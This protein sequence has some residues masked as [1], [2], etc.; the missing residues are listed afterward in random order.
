MELSYIKDNTY[1]FMFYIP[2]CISYTYYKNYFVGNKKSI[3][4]EP[5]G[6]KVPNNAS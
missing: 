5:V 1:I 6:E 2:I 4:L 3:N